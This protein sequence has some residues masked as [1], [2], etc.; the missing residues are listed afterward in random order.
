M[1]TTTINHII[2]M[3]SNLSET[4]LTFF[5]GFSKE[6]ALDYGRILS[7]LSWVPHDVMESRFGVDSCVASRM[8]GASLGISHV[9]E[10]LLDDDHVD[11]D[12][13]FTFIWSTSD[14][15]DKALKAQGKFTYKPFIYLAKSTRA[16]FI[17][18]T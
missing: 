6:V 11:F 10:D 18:T 4:N 9:N 2:V 17:S 14:T 8:V 15:L 7:C 1:S 5:Q 12:S 13:C 3:P 16:P